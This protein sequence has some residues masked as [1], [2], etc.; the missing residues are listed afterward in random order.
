MTS[1]CKPFEVAE[2]ATRI[3]AAVQR[4]NRSGRAVLQV[5][6][7]EWDRI[8][9]EVQRQG[10]EIDVSPKEFSFTGTLDAARGPARFV[11]ITYLRRKVDV[12]FEL[13]LMRTVRGVGY[14]IGAEC[15]G[16]DGIDDV[17]SMPVR[18]K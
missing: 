1:S 13:A 12:G 7:L 15:Y 3:R 4:G 5:N 9:H 8:T 17:C 14:Q 11:Y 2:L 18:R 6:D 16:G 10:R